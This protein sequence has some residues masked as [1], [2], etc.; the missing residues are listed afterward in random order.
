MQLI[1]TA[2]FRVCIIFF[3]FNNAM[4]YRSNNRANV[5][6]NCSNIINW[7]FDTFEFTEVFVLKLIKTIFF[8]FNQK[9]LR[10][11][12]KSTSGSYLI[13]MFEE[14]FIILFNNATLMWM[15]CLGVFLTHGIISIGTKQ[16]ARRCFTDDFVIFFSPKIRTFRWLK[17]IIG[18]NLWGFCAY[19]I[20]FQLNIGT[21]MDSHIY[22][23]VR[24]AS[25]CY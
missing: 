3:F 12:I 10:N 23:S 14:P 21:H 8:F 19:S 9:Y 25:T 2:G 22:P 7:R 15:G 13:F 11:T 16:L 18:T 17:R 5:F 20:F 6:I 4:T 24:Y 1:R